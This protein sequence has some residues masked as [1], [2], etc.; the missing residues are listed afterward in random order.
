MALGTTPGSKPGSL[1]R[2]RALCRHQV[3]RRGRWRQRGAAA[4]VSAP[5][6]SRPPFLALLEDFPD[7]I[8][9]EV[10]ERLDPLDLAMLGR[11]RT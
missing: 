2:G 7:L 4:G 5:E 10:L 3:R 9:K 8:Q 11:M 6:S 1:P